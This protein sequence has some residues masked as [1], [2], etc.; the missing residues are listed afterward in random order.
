MLPSDRKS[1]VIGDLNCHHDLWD[2]RQPEDELGASLAEWAT[3]HGW[4]AA[5]DGE[6]TFQSRSH[7]AASSAP[8]VA[9]AH[10]HLLRNSTWRILPDAGSDHLPTILQLS[11]CN[12]APKPAK[13]TWS[14]KK[15]NW[16]G[17]RADIDAALE[18]WTATDTPNAKSI[19][20]HK[21]ILSSAESNIP[22]G[23]RKGAK[24][25]WNE[26]AE[27]A[28]D[29]RRQKRAA[30]RT[31]QTNETRNAWNKSSQEAKK[32]ILNAKRQ[33]WQDFTSE[34]NT[35]TDCSKIHR[36]FKAIN[37]ESQ[38]RSS[39]ETLVHKGKTLVT[40]RDKSNAF[41][42]EYASVNHL[43][44][45]HIRDPQVH[46]ELNRDQCATCSNNRD[47]G[48]CQ[49]F[50]M[51]E[52]KRALKDIKTGKAAGEDGVTNNMLKNLGQR[53]KE[54]LLDTINSAWITYGIPST[55]KK[56]VII[57]ILKKGKLASLIGS[58]RP[59]SLM[60]CVAKLAERML[61]K[62]IMHWLEEGEHLCTEQAGFRIHRSTEDQVARI[63]QQVHDG[64]QQRPAKRFILTLFDFSRAFDRVW[65]KGLLLKLQRLGA[66]T[67]LRKW[68]DSFLSG[69][70]CKVDFN[71]TSSRYKLFRD[72]LPQGSALSPL[73]FIVFINDLAIELNKIP[74]ISVSLFADDL[75]V[76]ACAATLAACRRITQQ[77]ADVVMKW[78][79][80]WKSKV[81][82]EKTEMC[83]L[84]TAPLDVQ[85]A[86]TITITIGDTL[87]ETTKNPCF[88]GVHFDRLIH[89]RH[90]VEKK[91]KNARPKLRQL[92]ALSGTNWG[93][94]RQLLRALYLSHIRAGLEYAGG[95]WI[96]SLG[97]SSIEVLERIQ[98]S[99][100]RVITGCTRS[101][102]VSAL[103]LEADL[104][105]M[106]VRGKQLAAC[107]REKALRMPESHPNRILCENR[108]PRKRLKTIHGWRE[109]GAAVSTAAG[110]ED[111]PRLPLPTVFPCSPWEETELRI[112]LGAGAVPKSA[113]A[114]LRK[115]AAETVLR[116][117]P[118]PLAIC[119]WTDGS[120]IEGGINAGAAAHIVWDNGRVDNLEAA[121]GAVGSS[122]SA[123]TAAMY[124]AADYLMEKTHDL[125]PSNIA[126]CTDSKSLLDKLK[127]GIS[128]KDSLILQH[129]RCNLGAIS[130]FHELHLVWVPGHADIEG[131]EAV[132][133]LAKHATTFDQQEVAIDYQTAKARIKR[134]CRDT[135]RAGVR[136][137]HHWQVTGGCPPKAAPGLSRYEQRIMAQLRTGHSP[138]CQ[139][140][141]HRIN[142]APSPLCPHCKEGPE[143][144]PHLILDCAAWTA[145]RRH[146]LG[147]NPDLTVLTQPAGV[148]GFLRRIGRF[149]G[150]PP[151]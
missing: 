46:A 47:V 89:F 97:P 27:A 144:V 102:P 24:V 99:A 141:L 100:A 64:F 73:L 142:A 66:P 117:L 75:A 149:S 55:W 44:R 18:S 61:A 76:L 116:A 84:S 32:V 95:A 21:A 57:A 15:A 26:E 16:E 42:T 112:N 56:A 147:L 59:I 68:L 90:H 106:E 11:R 29:A 31:Q 41:V 120:L 103:T 22:R 14:Y 1:V 129:L 128:S 114:H 62:R 67:C 72:G 104:I 63:V 92:R 124:I 86:Q 49:P 39:D 77:A 7:S 80:E 69:R 71:N 135:W 132:D 50:K 145:P 91:V 40:D 34:L 94:D 70:Q 111:L 6:P 37:S 93:C 134:L 81:A 131:N 98:R 3:T 30:H 43:S 60:S 139:A 101:T 146:F 138:L 136:R 133:A 4:T 38:P 148:V 10:T 19:K 85:A 20:L 137:D 108:P 143:D 83:V 35:T 17:F 79:L 36:I 9:L 58:Y 130:N 48:M 88:L 126:I 28:V 82:P 51:C 113:P 96:P 12:S 118:K 115:E 33:A 140:Y 74:G 107:H 5:N 151:D 123:E 54:C 78:A 150:R 122:Y 105:P 109:A 23:K 110:L 13:P 45:D 65:R 121:A 125:P 2:D 25:W 52:L 119:A 53:A 127:S 8:D 87:V